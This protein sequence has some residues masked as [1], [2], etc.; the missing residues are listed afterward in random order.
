MRW[1]LLDDYDFECDDDDDDNH[2]NETGADCQPELA[3]TSQKMLLNYQLGAEFD[4]DRILP[5]SIL[6]RK[7]L[8][9]SCWIF[10]F[11][12]LRDRASE[13]AREK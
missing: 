5:G 2:A 9:G 1:R 8:F 6:K 10:C 13:R 12:F 11:R 7:H 4:I 3:R